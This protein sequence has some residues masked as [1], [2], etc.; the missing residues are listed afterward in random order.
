M[1]TDFELWSCAAEGDSAA[2]GTLFDKYAPNVYNHCFRRTADWSAAEDLTSVV[3]L[4]A[5]RRRG[6]VRIRHESALPWLLGVANNVLRNR[7]RSLRR[8][9]TALDQLPSQAYEPDPAE[10]IAGRI[11][12]EHR[13]REILA[14]VNRLPAADR[15]VLA[16]CVWSELTYEEAAVALGIPVGTVRSRLSRARSRLKDL[17]G[18][19]AKPQPGHRWSE[20][21]SALRT[22]GE[23]L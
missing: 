16:L 14:M 18:R 9:R 8:H 2:F 12:D 21:F 11:D 20:R 10:D 15:E 17:L 4:E 5:W 22:K 6:E 23:K 19:E 3:F 1:S 7:Q 13:M